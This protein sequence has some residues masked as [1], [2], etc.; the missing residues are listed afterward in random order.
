MTNCTALSRQSYGQAG[1]P[2]P[3]P[4]VRASSATGM[5][6]H[7]ICQ[8]KS[9][10]LS[11]WSRGCGKRNS[12]R[13]SRTVLLVIVRLLP[14]LSFRVTLPL[15][16]VLLMEAGRHNTFR[17]YQLRT[18]SDL[19]VPVQQALFWFHRFERTYLF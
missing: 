17:G 11:I 2:N 15:Q 14:S 6:P 10:H 3:D 9:Q 18:N 7:P 13:Q 4:C 5:L 19:L 8:V 1:T 12:I 16:V